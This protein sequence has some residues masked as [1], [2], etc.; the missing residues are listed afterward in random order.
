MLTVE[1]P[2]HIPPEPT[3]Q[4]GRNSVQSQA[5]SCLPRDSSPSPAWLNNRTLP[6]RLKGA[7]P[8]GDGHSLRDTKASSHMCSKYPGGSDCSCVLSKRKDICRQ[9]QELPEWQVQPW[10]SKISGLIDSFFPRV[11]AWASEFWRLRVGSRPLWFCVTLQKCIIPKPVLGRPMG[12][13]SHM[14]SKL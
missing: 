10:V 11:I 5:L 1:S 9:C 7:Q 3:Q 13:S 8:S 14:E 6:Q 4:I 2:W 12:T